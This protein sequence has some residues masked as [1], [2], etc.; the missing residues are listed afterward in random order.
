MDVT[1]LATKVLESGVLGFF[2]YILLRWVLIRLHKDASRMLRSVDVNSAAVIAMQKTLL[3][4]DLT[5]TGNNPSTGKNPEERENKAYR[6][7]QE[8]AATLDH[9]QETVLRGG[10]HDKDKPDKL[11]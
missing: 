6:K 4:H 3:A 1:V 8:I 2:V 5:V 10:H 9:L 11:L 7:Y